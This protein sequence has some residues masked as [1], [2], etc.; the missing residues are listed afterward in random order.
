MIHDEWV[1]E[2]I[3]KRNFKKSLNEMKMKTQTP[4]PMR[5]IESRTMRKSHSSTCVH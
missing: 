5:H 1:K 4:E 3:R 2:E